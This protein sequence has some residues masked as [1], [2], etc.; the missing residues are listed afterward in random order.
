MVSEQHPFKAE[1]N[2]LAV[3]LEIKQAVGR[4]LDFTSDHSQV[5]GRTG[6]AGAGAR[7]LMNDP[8]FC[9]NRLHLRACPLQGTFFSPRDCQ[10]SADLKK[11]LEQLIAAP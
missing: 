4:S 8:T 2:F 7:R 11:K 3:Q 1:Y 6:R 10:T 9:C 5:P